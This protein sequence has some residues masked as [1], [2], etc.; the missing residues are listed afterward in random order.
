[1]LCCALATP[2]EILGLND[3]CRIQ[4]NFTKA[5]KMAHKWFG[6]IPSCC[7]LTLLLG[8]AWVLLKYV[9]QTIFSGPVDLGT[10]RVHSL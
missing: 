2:L 5:E 1:M 8:S 7:S 6:E 4:S 10:S 3:Q 9:L